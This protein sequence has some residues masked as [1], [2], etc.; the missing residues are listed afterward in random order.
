MKNTDC[1]E[2]HAVK[3][4]NDPI[5]KDE[6]MKRKFTPIS[7]PCTR[8]RSHVRQFRQTLQLLT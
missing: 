3:T 7:Q 4:P 5:L 2:L 6:D 1:A 8:L